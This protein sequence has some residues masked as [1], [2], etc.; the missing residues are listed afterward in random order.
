MAP[1]SLRRQ[2]GRGTING[3]YPEGKPHVSR[4]VRIFFQN[5]VD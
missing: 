2:T 5:N 4:G 3:R 1:E